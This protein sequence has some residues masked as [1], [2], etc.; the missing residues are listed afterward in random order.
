MRENNVKRAILVL[1]PNSSST[2]KALSPQARRAIDGL[3]AHGYII[4]DFQEEELLINITEHVLV[5]KHIPMTD[6][7]KIALLKNYR[8]SE[9]Q[10]PRIKIKDPIARYY[11]L[12]RGQVNLKYIILIFFKGCENYSSK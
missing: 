10:L 6:E 1:Q 3:A 7:E 11:G 8:L 12:Q 5:P 2:S 4:E 9:S